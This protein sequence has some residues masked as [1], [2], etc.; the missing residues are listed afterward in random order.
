M[1]D[2][3]NYKNTK[4]QQ[5]FAITE[6]LFVAATVVTSVLMAAI[7]QPKLPPFVGD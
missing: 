7:T 5:G 1:N 4:T 2:Q 3:T 6:L